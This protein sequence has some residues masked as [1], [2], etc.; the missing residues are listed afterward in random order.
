M[1][2]SKEFQ[3]DL[4]DWVSEQ[5]SVEGVAL[6]NSFSSADMV[7]NVPLDLQS[8]S[9]V[10]PTTEVQS[11]FV[12]TGRFPKLPNEDNNAALMNRISDLKHVIKV[13]EEELER[14]K[15][16]TSQL[17]NQISLIGEELREKDVKV[18]D[19]EQKLYSAT[20][21]Y[22]T[23]QKELL[24]VLKEAEEHEEHLIDEF[25]QA[26][27][28][29]QQNLLAECH[30]EIER[31]TQRV[32]SFYVAEKE[33]IIRQ[34]HQVI[35]HI[36]AQAHWEI[37]RRH[38][39]FVTTLGKFQRAAQ[40]NCA[41]HQQQ[42]SRSWFVSNEVE[43]NREKILGSG[44]FGKVYKGTF[45]GTPVAVKELHEVIISAHNYTLFEREM[46][47]ASRLRHQNVVLF[48]AAT[49]VNGIPLIVT[50]YANGGSLASVLKDN[51]LQ[52]P[53]VVSIALDVAQGILY[54]HLHPHPV[55]HRDIKPDNVLIFERGL[56]PVRIA[57]ISDLGA[58]N[59]HRSIMTPNPGTPLYA[60]PETKTE[61]YTSKADVYSFGLL[62]LE[63]CVRECPVPG[64]VEIQVERVDDAS[65]NRLIKGC[66]QPI[67]KN[68]LN[69][70]SVVHELGQ[71]KAAI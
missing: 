21:R 60:A 62:V 18:L 26:K 61:Q 16:L 47:I 17:L 48:M 42:E 67:S 66:I 65:L 4:K 20:E 53:E 19:L 33:Q 1:D 8:V 63:M 12:G 27:A 68:R 7:K 40:E 35:N 9:H 32:T 10:A 23:I 30:E 52:L 70:Q 24:K 25:N 11:Q 58:A 5:H 69:M 49:L 29:Y 22:D 44:A 36:R 45:R 13:R 71:R 50:E 38:Q 31:Q 55:L 15:V 28:S 46:Q 14:E 51:T 64:E 37:E 3:R 43:V 6:Q 59:L 41:R 54:L 34:A 56:P 39:E 2:N 57:K